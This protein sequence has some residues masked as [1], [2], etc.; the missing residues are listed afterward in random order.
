MKELRTL[1]DVILSPDGPQVKLAKGTKGIYVCSK[2]LNNELYLFMVNASPKPTSVSFMLNGAKKLH[3]LGEQ[4]TITNS[5]GSFVD[6]FDSIQVHV[7]TTAK[8]SPVIKTITQTENELAAALASID[9][10]NSNNLAYFKHG[11]VIKTSKYF[12]QYFLNNGIIDAYNW[13]D[14]SKKI[15]SPGMGN[16]SMDNIA[17][18]FIK[19]IFPEKKR[20]SSVEMYTRPLYGKNGT[21]KNYTISIKQNGSWHEIVNRRN[22]QKVNIIENFDVVE[23]DTVLIRFKQQGLITINEI[24]IP[25]STK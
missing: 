19:I 6:T 2:K 17:G 5:R 8:R 24:R 1:E 11:T 14:S 22:N 10:Q 18:I 25:E 13:R 9:A 12:L 7:Y 4:R 3:V 20:F 23:S 21:P 15:Y 16:L